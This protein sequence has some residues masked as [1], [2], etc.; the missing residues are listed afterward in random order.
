MK[1]K[2]LAIM[3]LV[4]GSVFAQSPFSNGAGSGR[5][6]SADRAPITSPR[7]IRHQV[8]QPYVQPSFSKYSNNTYADQDWQRGLNQYRNRGFGQVRERSTSF[9][10]NQNR[11]DSENSRGFGEDF[12][13]NYDDNGFR[14]G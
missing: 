8:A 12:G 9:Q 11:Q 10:R 4:G 2:L 3:L 1:T 14:G 5:F 13:A 6:A 7:S